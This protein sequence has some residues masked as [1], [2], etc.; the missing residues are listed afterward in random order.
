VL[1][2]AVLAGLVAGIAGNPRGA[3]AARAVSDR[4]GARGSTTEALPARTLLFAHYG[5]GRRV[6]L[7][8]A[9]GWDR[10]ARHGTALLIPATTMV[11]V[12]SLGPQTLA[13]VLSLGSRKLVE[14]VVENALGLDFDG[15]VFLSDTRLAS[16]LAPA[17]RLHVDLPTATRIDDSAGTISFHSGNQ[18]IE[19][20]DAMRLLVAKGRDE[21]SHL[22]TVGAVLDGWRSALRRADVANATVHLDQRLLPLAIAAQAKV[23]NSTLPVERLSSGREERFR[24]RTPDA[25]VTVKQSF[26]WAVITKGQRPRIEVLNGVGGVALTQAVALR[27]VPAGGEVTLTGNLPGFGVD[28]TRVVYYRKNGLAAAKR[29]AAA[30]GVGKVVKAADAI[31][32]VDVTIIVGK[33]FEPRSR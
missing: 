5:P 31:D 1:A 17:G 14:V 19:P 3:T 18:N 15:S 4:D 12:P 11:E 25:F 16:V 6:D 32:V 33:D 21:L 30:L 13:D 27:V 8:V 10:G 7:L 2:F 24:L 28:A 20:A 26:P 9:F 29:M 23:H 22:I